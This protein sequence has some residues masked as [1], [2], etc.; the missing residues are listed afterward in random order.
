MAIRFH[1]A[2]NVRATIARDQRSVL[3]QG[4]TTPAW[5][6]RNDAAEV[7]IEHSVHYED[8]LPRQTSQ[9][10]LRA[11]APAGAG[12]RIRWKLAQVPPQA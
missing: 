6:L 11:R 10:V 2:P 8:G 9:V 12:A 1:L 3:I 7:A 5:W 4:P